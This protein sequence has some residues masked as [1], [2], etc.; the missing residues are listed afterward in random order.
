MLPMVDVMPPGALQREIQQTKPF[1][2]VAEEAALCLLRTTDILHRVLAEVTEPSGI[3]LQMFA[4]KPICP[5][6]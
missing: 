4:P 2:S 6:L 5:F 1:A 3:T